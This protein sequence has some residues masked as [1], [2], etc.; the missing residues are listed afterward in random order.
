MAGDGFLL[1]LVAGLAADPGIEVVVADNGLGPLVVDGL[2]AQGAR[3]VTMG[4]NVGFGAAVNRA[5]AQS[6][7]EDV[8]LLNDDLRPE[9]GF[10]QRLCARLDDAEMVAGVMVKA[11]HPDTVENGGVVV[12]RALSA[13]DHL[14]GVPVASLDADTPAPLGPCGGA[15]AFRR[16]VFV[17]AGG[18][19][20]GFF[21][22][23]EDVD[24]ALRL[25]VAGARCAL[26]YDARALHLGSATSGGYQSLT[27]AVI[28]GE[29]RGYFF[30]KYGLG[31]RPLDALAVGSIE[32]AASLA[33]AWRLKSLEPT[34]ARLRGYRRCAIRATRPPASLATMTMADGLRQRYGRSM[35]HRAA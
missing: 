23:M 25:H 33:L 24:L 34:R 9:D 26:A 15:A 7:G 22:Y 12:D 14:A 5:V 35:R 16:D 18:F 3:I 11:E 32:V 13:Y 28:V 17:G 10:V 29:S 30:R 31:S 8:V 6:E 1:D 21:A 4:R 20:E 19:D 2:R 27:K